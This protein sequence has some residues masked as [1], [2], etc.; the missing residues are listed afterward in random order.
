MP[1]A[2]YKDILNFTIELFDDLKADFPELPQEAETLTVSEAF[3]KWTA[4]SVFDA[5]AFE[6]RLV[7]E[8]RQVRQEFV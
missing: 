6:E 8:I 5:A 7:E 4:G 2:D 3:E 1:D